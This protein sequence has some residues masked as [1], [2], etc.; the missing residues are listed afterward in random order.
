MSVPCPCVM[1]I[2]GEASGD[3]HGARLL[4]A[5]RQQLPELFCCGIGGP[6]LRAAGMRILVEA[7]ELSV[8]GITEVLGRLPRIHAA[9]G[10]IKRALRGLHPE[11]LIL[12]DFP[13]FNLHLAGVARKLGIPVLY[14]ISPQ[15]WA[16]RAGRVHKI[17]RRV[18]HMAVILPFEEPLYHDHEIPVSFVGHPLMDSAPP[19]ESV[20]TSTAQAIGL[21]PGSRHGEIVRLLPSML[22]AAR[23]L[24]ERHPQRPLLI[25]MAPGVDFDWIQTI[26]RQQGLSGQIETVPG[27]AAAVFSRC[28]VVVAASG[29][30]TLEAAIHGVP[31]VI[32]YRVSSLSYWLAR[33]LVHVPFIGLVNLVAGMRV[34]AELVQHEATAENIVREVDQLLSDPARLAARRA[35]LL[36]VRERLG[37]AGASQRVATIALQLLSSGAPPGRSL[38]RR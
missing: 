28:A 19:L 14:Y 17:A 22:Q 13:D 16:W 21:L 1:L 35:E 10:R 20:A 29:T 15:V 25:S 27:G 24:R 8:V 37:G 26:V 31:M 32:I 3:A 18:A 33:L 5:M 6:A 36:A 7:G 30:V 2:A 38:G 34:A 9:L 12:I 4:T 23:L 11:L